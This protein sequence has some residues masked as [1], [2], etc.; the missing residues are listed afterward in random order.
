[1]NI[2]QND[3]AEDENSDIDELY[4]LLDKPTSSLND[5]FEAEV[6]I[7]DAMQLTD[8]MDAVSDN[9]SVLEEL[10]ALLGNPHGPATNSV[11]DEA[12]RSL[13]IEEDYYAEEHVDDISALDE[14]KNFLDET[15]SSESSESD[16][17]FSSNYEY[18]PESRRSI[19]DE[20][21]DLLQSSIDELKYVADGNTISSL[22]SAKADYPSRNELKNLLEN[23]LSQLM[24]I[25]DDLTS[26]DSGESASVLNE[27]SA[28]LGETGNDTDMSDTYMSTISVDAV[29]EDEDILPAE[30]VY[31]SF[32]NDDVIGADSVLDEFV[33]LLPE[34]TEIQ[35]DL[36]TPDHDDSA[37]EN[38][39]V[40]SVMD[41]LE[42]YFSASS[43]QENS[44]YEYADT[45][46]TEDT[47]NETE[48]DFIS[49]DSDSSLSALE[50][51]EAMLAETA[52]SEN[53]E[54]GEAIKAIDDDFIV[55]Q[56]SSAFPVQNKEEKDKATNSLSNKVRPID[57]R[58]DRLLQKSSVEEVNLPAE[59]KNNKRLPMMAILLLVVG[60]I[61][62]WIFSNNEHG[63]E[64]RLQLVQSQS[65]EKSVSIKAEAESLPQEEAELVV[66]T[67]VDNIADLLTSIESSGYEKKTLYEDELNDSYENQVQSYAEEQL[68]K[69][70]LV[71]D[72]L[73]D[74]PD[75]S[76]VEVDVA[77]IEK[78][79]VS[80]EMQDDRLKEFI[81]QQR[82]DFQGISEKSINLLNE[83]M[84]E[85]ESSISRVWLALDK[86][87]QLESDHQRQIKQIQDKNEES[88]VLINNRMMESEASVSELQFSLEKSK[89]LESERQLQM[90]HVQDKQEENIILLNERISE[91]EVPVPESRSSLDKSEQLEPVQSVSSIVSEMNARHLSKKSITRLKDQTY[92]I[93][94]VH[95]FAYYG[96]PP[97]AGELD[98]LNVAGV[99]YEI[100]KVTV[101]GGVWYR[102]LV[103]NSSEYSVAK[104]YAA[105]LKKRLAI[106]KIWISKKQ[107]IY[108]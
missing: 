13:Q 26:F 95:L 50:Q 25:S 1:M 97:P 73:T 84:L 18:S 45:E 80:N 14:L 93:W 28:L 17:S 71:E 62:W 66:S 94:S 46:Y 55:Q 40:N 60:I 51:L 30:S 47:I 74:E 37:D 88:M 91:P 75:N 83:R 11:E 101:N 7:D 69:E 44:E 9:V 52:S 63:M 36:I 86:S 57:T 70:P 106:K 49:V 21:Q 34:S 104:E 59:V 2:S 24:M 76:S 54:A 98:F 56:E 5:E 33:D 35:D 8:G 10:E 105:M 22:L 4:S 79:E 64:D 3:I 43:E 87:E 41:E 20:L 100:E 96:K 29:A 81:G 102:V 27:L 77:Q 23:K 6:H 89:R 39:A 67:K 53:D 99:P 68:T 12:E 82:L 38:S 31:Q 85:A 42:A 90:K 15:S 103:N 72:S 61:V 48:A 78:Y 108:D 19:L 16:D 32:S 58:E 107:Y 65:V 92:N